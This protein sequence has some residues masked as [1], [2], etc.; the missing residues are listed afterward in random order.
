MLRARSS[1]DVC[2]LDTF[3]LGRSVGS[4]R[5]AFGLHSV[6]LSQKQK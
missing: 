6:T 5:S 1:G 4:L 3:V 2:T